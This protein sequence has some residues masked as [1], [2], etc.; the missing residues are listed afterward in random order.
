MGAIIKLPIGWSEMMTF[1]AVES[2]ILASMDWGELV[3]TELSEV[4][5][6]GQAAQTHEKLSSP[7]RKR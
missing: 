2:H 6:P 7:S 1:F 5:K 3:E 4:R